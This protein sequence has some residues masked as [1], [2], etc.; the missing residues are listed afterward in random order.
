M[1]FIKRFF[2]LCPL[3]GVFFRGSIYVLYTVFPFLPTAAQ[4]L[5]GGPQEET[6]KLE[7]QLVNNAQ[8]PVSQTHYNS[9][10]RGRGKSQAEE[11]LARL[12]DNTAS[13][14]L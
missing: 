1:S 10:T 7:T 4:R 8:R 6:A 9:R 11:L 5:R 13:T 14:A 12:Q 3:F 2:L